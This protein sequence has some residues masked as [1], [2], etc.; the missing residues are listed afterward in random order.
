MR[1]KTILVL[2][3]SLAVASLTTVSVL[4]GQSQDISNTK[5]ETATTQQEPT[6]E[7]IPIID[8]ENSAST[9]ANTDRQTRTMRSAK[10]TRYAKRIKGLI[11]DRD[12]PGGMILTSQ[13]MPASSLS[14]RTECNYRIRRG[15]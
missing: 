3:V 11:A 6:L 5:H 2:L 9:L 1:N 4:R 14:R 7:H 15:G 8:F 12:A 10:G 13:Y